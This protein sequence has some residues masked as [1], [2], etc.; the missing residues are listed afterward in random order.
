MHLRG[1]PKTR[2]DWSRQELY[3]RAFTFKHNIQIGDAGSS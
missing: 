1:S 2:P 3:L